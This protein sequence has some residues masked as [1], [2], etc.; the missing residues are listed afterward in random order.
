MKI[1]RTVT[2]LQYRKRKEYSAFNQ[3][4][5]IYIERSIQHNKRKSTFQNSETLDDGL[6]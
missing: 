4:T 2:R 3:H 6:L 1:R 5:R